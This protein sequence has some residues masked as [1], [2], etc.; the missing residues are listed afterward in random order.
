MP[1][2]VGTG[3][4]FKKEDC[5]EYKTEEGAMKAAEKKGLTVWD[6]DGNTISLPPD[7]ASGSEM[8]AEAAPDNSKQTVGDAPDAVQSSAIRTE[9]GNIPVAGAGI[10]DRQDGQ[11]ADIVPQGKMKVTVICEGSLNLRRS[12]QYGNGNICGRA[13]KGQSYQVEE[14]LEADG[15]KFVR[16][17][18]GIYLSGE[19]EHVRFE[20]I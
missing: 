18:G 15:R 1:Y 3:K 7:G 8:Q 19:P 5:K 20:Q 12:P 14:I 6:G 4:E 11:D 17:V 2:Y 10:P 13:M 9:A 16:T